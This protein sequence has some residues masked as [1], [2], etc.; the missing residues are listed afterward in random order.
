MIISLYTLI[1]QVHI[2]WQ[3]PFGELVLVRRQA[4]SKT[5]LVLNR[6]VYMLQESHHITFVIMRHSHIDANREET[7][8][9]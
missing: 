2:S 3:R 8:F 5:I 6:S 1:S 7:G 9:G 4:I